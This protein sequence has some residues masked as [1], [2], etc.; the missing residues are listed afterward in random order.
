MSPELETAALEYG[1]AMRKQL[2]ESTENAGARAK[3]PST[4]VGSPRSRVGSTLAR[5]ARK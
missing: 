3:E 2:S 1:R 4:Q 5:S